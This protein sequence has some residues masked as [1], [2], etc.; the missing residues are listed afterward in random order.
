[1]DDSE[2]ETAR[3][4]SR[5]QPRKRKSSGKIVTEDDEVSEELSSAP[6]SDCIALAVR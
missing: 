5:K 6:D 2:A 3:K 1:M 4:Q